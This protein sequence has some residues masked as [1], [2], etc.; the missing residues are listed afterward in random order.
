MDSK[1]L[2]P[3]VYHPEWDV[4]PVREFAA[5]VDWGLLYGPE[6]AVMN[7]AQPTSVVLAA[8]SEISVYPKG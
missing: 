7:A 3:D 5:D 4:Y 8:G 2:Y 6:W 1:V